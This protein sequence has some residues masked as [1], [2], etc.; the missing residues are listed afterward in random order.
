M[1]A[2]WRIPYQ[3]A[4]GPGFY[5]KHRWKKKIKGIKI[6]NLESDVVAHAFRRKM[7]SSKPA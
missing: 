4:Q 7:E 3:Q 1:R 2:S 6:Y 5:P